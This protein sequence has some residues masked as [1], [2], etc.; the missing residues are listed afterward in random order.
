MG[1]RDYAKQVERGSV[2]TMS[3][4]S[5]LD[6][7]LPTVDRP[8]DATMDFSTGKQLMIRPHFIGGFVTVYFISLTNHSSSYDRSLQSIT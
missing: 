2:R 1:L 6:I 8:S 4:Q 3:F 5:Y 7:V